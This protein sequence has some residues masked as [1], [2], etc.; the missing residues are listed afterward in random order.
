V[1][2]KT[3]N[4]L[5]DRTSDQSQN[6]TQI[7]IAHVSRAGADKRRRPR[8]S[9]A[10]Q[11]IIADGDRGRRESSE[12][13]V[14][15]HASEARAE[16]WR[17]RDPVILEG[18]AGEPQN[19]RTGDRRRTDAIGDVGVHRPVRAAIGQSLRPSEL[20]A[21]RRGIATQREGLVLEALG[22]DAENDAANNGSQANPDQAQ[23]ELAL[24]GEH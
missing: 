7:A 14:Y 20:R 4:S 22:L 9:R 2:R 10:A 17:H 12:A 8:R 21:R 15:C 3:L 19:C 23:R 16:L 5:S 6:W 11:Y 13:E 24:A 18:R 1:D